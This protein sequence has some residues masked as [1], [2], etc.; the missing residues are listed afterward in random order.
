M[1]VFE[2]E[3]PKTGK[4][5]EMDAPAMPSGA[6]IE[7]L[8]LKM[9][10]ASQS[11]PPPAAATADMVPQSTL[12]QQPRVPAAGRGTGLDVRTSE[13]FAR[14][15]RASIPFAGYETP[16][17]G[18]GQFGRVV[19]EAAQMAIPVG[20]AVKVAKTVLPNAAR[21]GAKFQRVMAAAKDVPVDI[22][23][24]GNVALRIQQ[25]ADRGA[26]MPMV[27]RKFLSRVTD[28]E[29][30]PFVYEEARDFASNIS[31]L[32]AAEFGRL[33]PV[34]AREVH[35]LRVAL[36]QAIESAAGT[37]GKAPE[38]RSAMK[39]YGQAA[40]MREGWKGVKDAAVKYAL[41]AGGTYWALDKVRDAISGD[42]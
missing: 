10:G 11:A 9:R 35:S 31:R 1:P 23:G 27:V 34:V 32:S 41:P 2:I 17:S 22:S 30:G 42:R 40:K 13:D 29:K 18:A 4:V 26:S 6:Q 20:G 16:D 28:P 8:L 3:D 19:G 14:G 38:L 36:N 12:T 37:V 33:T 7:G 15:A 25:L 21:A 5:Y 39:E 24:P